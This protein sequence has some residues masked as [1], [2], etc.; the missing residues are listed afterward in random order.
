MWERDFFLNDLLDV[1]LD[2]IGPYNLEVTS[3]GPQR[4]LSKL[5]DYE[6][7]KGRLAKIKTLQPINGQK[8]FTGIIVGSVKESV[9]LSLNE[10]TIV[11]PFENI[12]KARLVEVDGEI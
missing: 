6:R 2:N 1:D 4:P 7:F 9:S 8:N 5:P 11:I 10:K 3:P 12:F